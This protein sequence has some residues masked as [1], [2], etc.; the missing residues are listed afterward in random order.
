IAFL[1]PKPLDLLL[2]S[3]LSVIENCLDDLHIN[4]FSGYLN[5]RT[6]ESIDD[7]D[8]LII[9]TKVFKDKLYVEEDNLKSDL[10][11]AEEICNHIPNDQIPIIFITNAKIELV[12]NFNTIN[13]STYKRAIIKRFAF[14]ALRNNDLNF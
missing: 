14:K 8:I 13:I 9:A 11:T 4:L 10:L 5:T 3:E 1:K 6:L 7:Y 12:S 2:D